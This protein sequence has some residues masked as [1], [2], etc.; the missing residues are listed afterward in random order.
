MRIIGEHKN[1]KKIKLQS[2]T[3]KNEV[4]IGSG[5]IV[6]PTLLDSLQF[7]T[8]KLSS[9]QTQTLCSS[10]L[11]TLEKSITCLVFMV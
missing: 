9:S 3:Y 10:L 4:L 1:K 2:E 8:F 7:F 6:P 11:S 5:M